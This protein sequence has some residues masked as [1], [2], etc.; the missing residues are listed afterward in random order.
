MLVLFSF[1]EYQCGTRRIMRIT[2]LKLPQTTAKP[3][4]HAMYRGLQFAWSKGIRNL[5]C[6]N[7]IP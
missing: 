7:Q 5:I 3:E 6:E 2:S 1:N 4:L